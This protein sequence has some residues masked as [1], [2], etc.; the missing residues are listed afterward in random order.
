MRRD[1][2]VGDDQLRREPRGRD[3]ERSQIA[4]GTA[5][6]FLAVGTSLGVYP[7][8]ALPEI[9][10][11]NGARLVILNAEETRFDPVADAVVRDQLGDV[12]PDLVARV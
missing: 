1:P 9:A 12:L 7:A 3:L 11:R 6:L 5:D 8:A 2:Q 10:R 4:A